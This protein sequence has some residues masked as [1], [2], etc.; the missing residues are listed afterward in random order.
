MTKKKQH[1]YTDEF[2]D[3]A[4]RLAKLPDRSIAGVALELGIPAWKLRNWI[5]D[6]NQTL[7]RR[8][9]VKE[10]IGLQNEIKRLKEENEI[11]KKAAAY[12]AKN[13]Q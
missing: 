11:L 7:E 13:L 6:A 4:V 5:Q 3:K 10:L 12:F 2:R 1:A 9:E 8:A